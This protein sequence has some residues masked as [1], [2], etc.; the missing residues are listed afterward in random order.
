MKR[1]TN[2]RSFMKSA[3]IA[4]G[5]V[6]AAG[7]LKLLASAL[8]DKARPLSSFD[9][10]S[11]QLLAR[12]SLAEKIGQM[13]QAE[14][15]ALK[16][17]DIEKYSPGSLLCGGSS[18]PKAGNSLAAWTDMY[19]GFQRQALQT[20]LA[21]PILFGVDAVH[22]HNNVLNAVVFPHNIGLGCTRNAALVEKAARI[23]AEEV[24][25]TGFNWAFAP[26]IAVPRDER[27]GRTYE[28]FGETAELA[29]TLGAAAVR[30]LQ[31]NDLGD[32]LAVLACAK[33]FVGD[34]GTAMGTGQM[35]RA[36]Q[37]LLDQGD[38]RLSE[39]EL[40][41][42]H[43]PGYVSAIKAG[44]GSI[45]VSYSSW[46]GVKAS[47][48]KRLLTEILKQELG[49]AGF[50]ISD[51]NA[52]SQIDP[53]FKKAI[54]TSIN[55]GMD[56]A[57][58]PSDYQRF[59]ALL[60]ELVNEGRVSQS[61]IDDAVIRILRVKF[62]MGL[63]DKGRSP[64]ADRQLHKTFGSAQHRQVARECVRQSLVL[65]RNERKTLPLSKRL[66]RIHVAGKCADDIGNQ[67]G[68]WT[69]DWQGKSGN[70]TTGGTTI[71][72]AIKKAVSPATKVTFS[73]DG[74]DAAGA[75]VGI[76]VIGESPYA[77]GR[78]D[79]EN[80]FLSTEDM[81]VIGKMKSAGM[82]FI[83]VL[84]SGRPLIINEVL[85]QCDAFMAAWLPGTEGQGVADVLFGNYKPTGK[86][87]CSWPKQMSQVPTNV[88]D[89]GYDPLFPYGFGLSYA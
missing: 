81:S 79:R 49:F 16:E 10:S 88:G 89:A 13:T 53:D 23:T 35:N 58:E 52:I 84:I 39:A 15:S 29:Q 46:N 76:A 55:A 38:T 65:L 25:A 85:S 63:M 86:L 27:W 47:A 4:S 51:Y 28:G 66:A 37:R 82:P 8:A 77:E 60:T 6:A 26:C 61:R 43:L 80:L 42:I 1:N 5:A 40:R 87:S 73:I 22:G 17:G 75:D 41:S 33:H 36:Q 18:D 9:Q 69:I 30:G 14:Q 48:S 3:A 19:D 11:R 78:G 50:L 32:P 2:R 45:M 12:M 67:C 70:V 20:R 72:N 71:L 57:M 7:P 21:I 68:G 62:A 64:L 31:R 59:I 54:E 44:V 83:I 56:M 74:A 34:G 24:R